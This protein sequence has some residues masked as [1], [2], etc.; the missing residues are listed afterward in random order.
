MAVSV[1]QK[2]GRETDEL[3]DDNAP[4]KK[5]RGGCAVTVLVTC[6]CLGARD[7]LQQL[8]GIYTLEVRLQCDH[9]ETR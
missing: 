8:T 6:G 3:A 1:G 4:K 5:V 2:R 9:S 7:V